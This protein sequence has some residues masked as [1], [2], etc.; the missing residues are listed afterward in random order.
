MGAEKAWSACETNESDEIKKEV[1]TKRVRAL[2]G[3]VEINFK[4]GGVYIGQVNKKCR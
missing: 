4:K 2:N 1:F 3:C